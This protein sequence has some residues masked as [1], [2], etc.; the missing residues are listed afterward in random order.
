MEEGSTCVGLPLLYF[1]LGFFFIFS[2]E[3][4]NIRAATS[5][6]IC[7]PLKCLPRLYIK[8]STEAGGVQLV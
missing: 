6:T 3:I 4:F 2:H 1:L 8:N 7:I 5:Y